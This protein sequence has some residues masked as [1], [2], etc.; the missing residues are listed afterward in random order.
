LRRRSTSLCPGPTQSRPEPP[1]RWGGCTTYTIAVS[2]VLICNSIAPV[3][4][5]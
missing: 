5:S 4:H 1:S 2:H 3:L